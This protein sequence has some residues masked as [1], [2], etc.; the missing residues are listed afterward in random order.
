MVIGRTNKAIKGTMMSFLQYGLQIILQALMAPL[1]LKIAGRE[2][3][4]AYAILMQVIGY[5]IL[6]DLGF[7][8]AL[9]RYLAQAF[10]LDGNGGRFI[11]TFNIGRTFYL[12][13]NLI[14][15]LLIIIF[16]FFVN[17][18]L[19][20]NDIILAQARLSCCLYGLW[21]IIRTPFVI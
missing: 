14:F 18:F 16:S 1:I 4:G 15:G 9:G 6:L 12:F 2:T 21:I 10:G 13:T 17:K 11:E 3:L 5:G 20:V 8:V 19:L 7:G